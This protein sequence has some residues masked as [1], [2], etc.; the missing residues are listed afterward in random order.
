MFS[1]NSKRQPAEWQY[2]YL[3]LSRAKIAAWSPTENPT[4]GSYVVLE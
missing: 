3:W 1:A 4:I 2:S